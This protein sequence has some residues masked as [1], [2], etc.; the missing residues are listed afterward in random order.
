MERYLVDQFATLEGVANVRM[1]GARRYAMRVWL[2]RENLAARQLTVADVENSLLRENV[3]LPAGPPRIQRTRIHAAHRHQPAHR[4]GLPQPGGGPR[5]G[6]LP[7]AARRSGRSAAGLRRRSQPLA[8]Q[9]HHRPVDGHHSAVQGQRARDLQCGEGAAGRSYSRRC[10]RT[11]RVEINID[12]GV[13]IAASL[14]NVVFALS[15]T[16]ILVLIVIFLFLGTLRA[17]LIPAVT[18]P[19][20]IVA[21]AIVML[22]LDY[23]INTLTL[24]ARGA[25][26]RPGGR[27]RHRGAREH[28]APHR[29]R[30][31]RGAGRASTARARSASP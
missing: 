21:A 24:L 5:A 1:N 23:S 28:R 12:N 15:E 14:K 29:G 18:I 8:L 17:T 19:V 2:S 3:E 13:F 6:R 25:G 27:R 11:S 9:R 22:A 7:G 16:L 30:R 31:A 4:G 20:S 10:R 26:H